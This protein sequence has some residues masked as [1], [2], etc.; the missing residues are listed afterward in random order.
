MHFVN[1]YSISS[2][3]ERVLNGLDGAVNIKPVYISNLGKLL[4][5]TDLIMGTKVSIPVIINGHILF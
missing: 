2:F 1:F 5:P 3:K 4:P